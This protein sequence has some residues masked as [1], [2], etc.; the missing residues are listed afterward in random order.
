MDFT[1][2]IKLAVLILLNM[3]P[4]QKLVLAPGAIFGGNTVDFGGGGG[5]SVSVRVWASQS[6]DYLSEEYFL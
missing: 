6:D 1:V 5:W 4:P 2:D 3:V